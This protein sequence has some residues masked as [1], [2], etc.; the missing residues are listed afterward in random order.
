LETFTAASHDEVLQLVVQIAALLF[1]A[2]L[3]GELAQRLK[4]PAVVGEIVAGV[5]LG[6]SLLSGLFPQLGRWI[7]PQTAIQGQ[8]L[9]VVSLI[10]VMMLL[11]LTGLEIDLGLIRRRAGTAVGVA[12]G[13]LLVPFATGMVLG[14]LMPADL[15]VDASNRIVFSLFLATALSISAIPVLAK[16]LL[17]LG[18]MRREIGQTMLAAGM[19][20]DI[21]GWTLLGLVTA[22]A[23]A[24]SIGLA[25]VATTLGTVAIFLVLTLSLGRWLVRGA[26]DLAQRG[27]RSRDRHLTVLIALA[28]GWGAV[29]QALRLEPVI[30][31]FA[32]GILFGRLR[33]LPVDAVNK[34]EAMT[35]GVFAPIFFGV[36]GLKV[37]A[38]G[39]LE[40]RM[41]RL[42]LLIIG[43]ATFGKVVGVYLGA[44]LVSRQGHWAALA[45]GSGL[46]ARGAVEIIVAS[47]G[48]SLGIIGQDIFSAVVVMAVVTSL[49]A[50]FA[51]RYTLARVPLDPEESQ[52]LQREEASQGSLM[53]GLRRVLLPVRTRPEH[54]TE[55]QPM[56][57]AVLRRLEERRPLAITLFSVAEGSNRSRANEHLGRISRAFTVDSEISTRVAAAEPVDAIVREAAR[58]YDL[59]I[60]GAPDI[61]QSPEV[62]FGEVVD[63]VVRLAPCPTLVV[64]GRPV[65][66][67]W[68]I[69]RI[70]VPTDGSSASRK[71]A[72]VAF[73]L[74][75]DDSVVA[76][77]HVVVPE[78]SSVLALTG[79][80]FGPRHRVGREMTDQ[81][82]QLGTSLGVL[83]RSDVRD[84]SDPE[85]GILA[86]AGEF[87]ADLLVLGTSVRVGTTRLFLGPRVE[88]LVSRAAC[89]V[90]VFNE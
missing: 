17:D 85:S 23:A 60:M 10:G 54:S 11:T 57:I 9:E 13:G 37:D 38:R 66:E 51:L 46:N 75:G 3:L 81:L 28:F 4:Q 41:L 32:I 58:D 48:L 52:R 33:R 19:I 35:L 70:L 16:I 84:A 90:L 56:S 15:L 88:R 73:A 30:G 6:P 59:V 87:G 61:S 1:F 68:N 20:D 39:L 21:T 25:M 12:L 72:E 89:P 86:A 77:V 78:G 62:L 63:D 76:I 67:E 2:R 43:V 47:I 53:Q 45:F 82:S 49:M 7:V 26:Y 31:A 44:R 74:A 50:P 24:G 65:P 18:L 5:L 79:S 40:P 29:T 69:R 71:A 22:L 8:L 64:S 14:Y 34:L 83:T 80:T 42:T 27:L 36:V 55:A